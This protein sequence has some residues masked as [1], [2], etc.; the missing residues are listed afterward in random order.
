MT[1]GIDPDFELL[2]LFCEKSDIDII[3]VCSKEVTDSANLMR[4]RVFA[5]R[6]GYLEDPA[7]GSGNAALGNY[8]LKHRRWDG[9]VISLEQNNNA[10]DPTRRAGDAR[11]CFW[12]WGCSENRGAVPAG[13]N[14]VIMT[15]KL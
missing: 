5:P 7:T 2:K 10:D 13:M 6:F 4:T 15:H 8:L 12:W 1:L 9:G 3:L 11:G 14:P